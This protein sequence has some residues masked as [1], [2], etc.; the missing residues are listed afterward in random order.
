MYSDLIGGFGAV[1]PFDLSGPAHS[2]IANAR[3]DSMR[4]SA[5]ARLRRVCLS[6][7]DAHEVEAWGAPTFRVNNKLFAMYAEP[8]NNH[9]GHEAVWVK[10]TPVNQSLMIGANPKRYFWPPYVG[11]SGWVGVRLDGRPNWKELTEVLRDAYELTVAKKRRP[12]ARPARATAPR[13]R[14]S[15][16]AHRTRR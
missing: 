8:G 11:T 2:C 14:G 16:P 1:R 4:L 15:A 7:P 12:S 9:G 5:L 13:K 10:Q 3:T 6:F